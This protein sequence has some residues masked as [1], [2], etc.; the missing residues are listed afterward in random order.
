M[1]ELAPVTSAHRSAY[2]S[3]TLHPLVEETPH[4]WGG[5]RPPA[6]S[7]PLSCPY[8][9]RRLRLE[10]LPIG[11]G[12]GLSRWLT[13]LLDAI[14]TSFPGI[15][16]TAQGEPQGE[17][18]RRMPYEPPPLARDLVL[19]RDQVR[20]VDQLAIERYGLPGI[21]LMENA[22]RGAAELLRSAGISGRITICCGRGNNGGDGFV[23]A[24]H[25]EN[26][27]HE[28]RVLFFGDPASLRGDA[29]I[30]YGV[31]EKSGMPLK[32]WNEP[33]EHEPLTAAL[34][35]SEWIVDALLGTGAVGVPR[36]PYAEVIRAINTA[37]TGGVKTL[38][39]DL[40]SG[41][42]ADGGEPFR[43]AEGRYGPCVKADLT[44]TFVA[45]KAGFL[46]PS[47]RE[48]TGNVAVVDIGAPRRA[49]EE[50]A[51]AA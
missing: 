38:A 17:D 10:K 19:T 21:V 46:K 22:G 31:V 9:N 6:P 3:T 50:A 7:P 35:G 29:A 20:R 18:D 34:A 23:I 8:R 2:A 44:A 11:A 43:D 15:P 5:G 27:G 36:S 32:V 13:L 48:F 51:G 4:R 1:P 12:W 42:D 47:A 25:L 49:L 39:V 26:A 24:R 40:P 14:L 30:Q 41:L 37:S 28:V 33:V 16:Q 45:R